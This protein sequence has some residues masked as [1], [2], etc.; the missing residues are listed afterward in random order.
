[1]VHTILVPVGNER[2][3]GGSGTHRSRGLSVSPLPEFSFHA[4]RQHAYS[5]RTRSGGTLQWSRTDVEAE[6][7]AAAGGEILGEHAI[8][9]DGD[10]IVPSNRHVLSRLYKELS[11]LIQRNGQAPTDPVPQVK[12]Q[13]QQADYAQGN[14]GNVKALSGE[15]RTRLPPPDDSILN[16]PGR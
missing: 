14:Q 10:I 11:G 7:L 16:P 13:Q 5:S 3:P 1:M 6:L 4:A 12:Q 9:A 8:V 2:G 15:E